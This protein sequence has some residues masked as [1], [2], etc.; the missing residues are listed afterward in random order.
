MTIDDVIRAAPRGR[1][2]RFL[3]VDIEGSE[4][5]FV[6]SAQMC[7]SGEVRP[8]ILIEY[9]KEK[10]VRR[11]GDP[12]NVRRALRAAGYV[13]RRLH[14]FDHV[15]RVDVSP[16]ELGEHRNLLYVHGSA[17]EM[18]HRLEAWSGPEVRN[19]EKRG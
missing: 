17:S 5:D 15:L 2:V 4:A 7:L 6:E 14:E 16:E 1:E 11:G 8:V 3:K 12:E 9:H 18:L 10:I 13:E 19:H